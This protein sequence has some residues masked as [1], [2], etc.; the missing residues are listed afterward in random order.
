[1]HLFILGATG[2][3]G[4]QI[5]DLALARGHR[6]TAFVRSPEKITRA[7]KGLTVI[8]G[9][10]LE[11]ALLAP[12]LAGHDA[13]LSSI[14]PSTR[15]ALRPSRLMTESAASTIAAMQLAGVARL[16]IVSAAVLFPGR[17]LQFAIFRRLLKHHATDLQ[18]MEAVVQATPFD[19]T[20]ARPPRLVRSPEQR[21]RTEREGLPLPAAAMSFRS[22]AAF[23]LDSV[24]QNKYLRTVVGLGSPVARAS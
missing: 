1:M 3:I 6:V 7:D 9:N 14:G 5:L 13:I 15:Q 23:L 22:V 11:P 2:H 4:S 24:E 17:G 10:P 19:W 18:A 20:I 8:G 16:G 21:Y 12:N